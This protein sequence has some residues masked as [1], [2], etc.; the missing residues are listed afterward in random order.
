MQYLCATFFV[1]FYVLQYTVW[2][3]KN[4]ESVNQRLVAGKKD[5][6]KVRIDSN[7]EIHYYSLLMPHK[8]KRKNNELKML[9]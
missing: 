4:T 9:N 1:T 2:S 7:Y 3:N 5:G 8:L 6:C